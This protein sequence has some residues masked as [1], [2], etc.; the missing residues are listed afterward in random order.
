MY[1]NRRPVVWADGDDSGMVIDPVVGQVALDISDEERDAF[2]ALWARP[3]CAENSANDDCLTFAEL[4]DAASSELRF[5]LPDYRNKDACAPYEGTQSQVM[6]TN[7]NGDCVYWAG[8]G[9][10][11]CLD[12]RRGTTATPRSRSP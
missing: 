7:E 4:K 1:T 2:R 11:A 5:V 9:V 10:H 6:G 3:P 12:A 8:P